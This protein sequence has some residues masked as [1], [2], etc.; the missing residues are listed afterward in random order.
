VLVELLH[1]RKLAFAPLDETRA[2]DLVDGL[3]IRP[4]LGGVRG[5][6][7]VDLTSVAMAVSR[8]SVI[9]AD[10]GDLLEALD[11]NPLIATRDG[12]VAVDAL[13]IPRTASS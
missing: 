5:A 8:L 10:L 9:A 1:D 13:V 11:V 4:I 6:P 3:Q 2:Q 7:P 12:C